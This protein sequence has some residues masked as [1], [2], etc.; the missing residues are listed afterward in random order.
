MLITKSRYRLLRQCP[1]LLWLD[2]HRPELKTESAPSQL[3]L[4]AGTLLGEMARG[5]FGSF[6]DVTVKQENGALDLSAMEEATRSAMASGAEIICEASFRAGALFCAVDLLRRQDG[7]WAIYEVK[8]SA[9][10]KSVYA[11]DIAF[12][13]YVLD[14]LGIPVTGVYLIHRNEDYVRGEEL[15]VQQLFKITDMAKRV[16]KEYPE[17]AKALPLADSV[18]A[19][20]EEPADPLGTHCRSPLDCPY[21]DYCARNLP[22]PSVF[23]LYDMKFKHKAAYYAAGCVS[24][25]D[26]EHPPVLEKVP[27]LNEIQQRQVAFQ[28]HHCPD[29]INTPE[30]RK[31]LG[32]LT[33]PLYFLD[34]ESMQVPIPQRPGDRAYAQIPFQ[35]SLHYLD[36]PGGTLMHAEFLGRSDED[37]R[38]ALAEQLCRDIPRGV[39]VTAYNQS[40]ECGRLKELAALFPDLREHLLDIHDHI[41]DL[42]EPFQQGHYY[43]RAMGGSFSIKSVLPA[44]F[45]DDPELDYHNLDLVHNGDEAM[46]LF[47]TIHTLPP[48]EQEAARA[49][50][51]TYCRLDTLAMVRVWEALIRAAQS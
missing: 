49:A 41:V 45:P 51:L 9:K 33:F 12:Q 39:C 50:L 38:R 21:W 23:D 43:T 35:Y 18:L 5:Y 2:A 46:N 8:S 17:V 40:F 16:A 30:I 7:G 42:L 6:T 28:L 24:F 36:S 48:E 10:I 26:L 13:K 31:F 37:P 27:P 47:P 1:K 44:L 34:F 32:R 19:A 11:V 15:D 14:Q 29:H 22:Q 3:R 25:G 4:E 20:R